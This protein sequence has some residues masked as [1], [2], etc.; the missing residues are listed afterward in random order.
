MPVLFKQI[1]FKLT[2]K[3]LLVPS[4][5]EMG[6]LVQHMD[7]D[8]VFTVAGT[9]YD[10]NLSSMILIQNKQ[11]HMFGVAAEFYKQCTDM[12]KINNANY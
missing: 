8:E 1:L 11:G 9:Y 5:F 2:K 3:Y 12:E 4:R 6:D 10:Q 7:G